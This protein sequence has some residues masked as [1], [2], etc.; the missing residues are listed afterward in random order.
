MLIVQPTVS[1]DLTAVALPQRDV[2]AGW[3]AKKG[4]TNFN[5]RLGHNVDHPPS[6]AKLDYLLSEILR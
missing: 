4:L 3:A 5:S 6:Y 2:E 1:L